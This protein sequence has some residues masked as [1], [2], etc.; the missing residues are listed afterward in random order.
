MT[1]KNKISSGFLAIENDKGL[2]AVFSTVGAGVYSLS[3]HGKNLIL[4]PKDKD[5]YLSS[6]QYFGKTVGRVI[7]RLPGRISILH[8]EYDLLSGEDGLCLH[9]GGDKGLAFRDF[10]GIVV[11]KENAIGVEFTYV[12][13]DG[14]CG[15]PGQLTTKVSYFIPKDAN[16]LIIRHEATTTKET[17]VSI[18]N[19]MYWNIF[20]DED[21]N[22]YRLTVHSSRVGVFKDGTRLIVGSKPVP[23]YLDFKNGLL[24][25]DSL[26]RIQK[27]KGEIDTLDHAFLFDQ[28]E[29]DQPKVLLESS[30]ARIECYTDYDGVNL[31]VDTTNSPVLFENGQPYGRRAIAIEPQCFPLEDRILVPGQVYSHEIR[32]RIIEKQ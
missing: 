18:S 25:K 13:P 2:R 6:P 19:H 9:G 11:S 22:G 30:K 5:V 28:I 15:F 31:Y 26:D 12:S 16:E 1:K 8:K 7:G 14:E 17:I 24:L 29:N 32:Y 4:Q 10:S 3:L 21:V 23:E 20:S 27:Q